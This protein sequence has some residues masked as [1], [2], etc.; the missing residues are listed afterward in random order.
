MMAVRNL[1]N[2]VV[3]AGF[4]TSI[5]GQYIDYLAAKQ[6]RLLVFEEVNNTAIEF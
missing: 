6:S 1:S 4:D 5:P 3:H 2:S